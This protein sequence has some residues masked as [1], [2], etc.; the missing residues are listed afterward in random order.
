VLQYLAERE[1]NEVLIEAGPTLSGRFLSASLI[2]ELVIY[3][4]FHLMGDGGRGLFNLP[5]LEQM[6]QRINLEVS[7]MR[8][9]GPDLRLTAT[10]RPP[11]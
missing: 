3:M 8:R 6:S 9:L 5:G 11:I 7:D 1:I 2:D 10:L 4:A